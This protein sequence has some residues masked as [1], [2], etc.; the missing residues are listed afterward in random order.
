VSV[1]AFFDIDGTVTKTTILDPLIWYRRAHDSGLRFAAFALGILLR[2]P[3]YLAVDRRSR[4]RCN[5]VFYRRYA[6]LTAADL[7]GWHERTF[8][9]NLQHTIFPAAVGCIR[10]HQRQGRPIIFVTG[11][12]DIVMGPLAKFLQADVLLATHLE[13]RDG[14]FTGAIDGPAIADNR[15]AELVRGLANE[16]GIDLTGSFAYGNSLGDAPML[17]C[18]GNPVTVN[19]DSRL[20]RLAD[21]CGWPSVRWT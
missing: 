3:Y 2:V 14:R 20:Q 19:P 16:H 17:E 18:V 13:E 6:G 12:L 15:K 10:E 5:V 1:A 8:A 7:R 11:G 9:E 4:A 21:K